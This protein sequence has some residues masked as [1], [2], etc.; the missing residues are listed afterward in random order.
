MNEVF[1]NVVVAIDGPS[2][3]GKSTVARCVARELHFVYVDSGMFYRALTWALL[4]AGVSPYVPSAV[5]AALPEVQWDMDVVDGAV[6]VRVN[7]EDPGM[8]LRTGLVHEAVADTAAIPEVRHSIVRL[9][10]STRRFGSLVMEGRDIGTV[11][12]PETQF[13][14]YLDADP[15]ER[16][17]RRAKDLAELEGH[18]DLQAVQASLER[19]DRRDRTRAEAPLQIALGAV[20]ID[21]TRLSIP[22]VTRRIVECVRSGLATRA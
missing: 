8:A 10:R 13:K 19:R 2:A 21:T 6:R 18:A 16:A 3:S 17:R 20:V 14:F 4:R 1:S 11:V 9:L 7:G 5:I 22:E 12:F 15:V